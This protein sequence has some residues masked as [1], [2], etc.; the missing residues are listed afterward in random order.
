MG[1]QLNSNWHTHLFQ[2]RNTGFRKWMALVELL[3]L[4]EAEELQFKGTENI[5]NKIIK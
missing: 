4:E 1:G 5:F 2:E 3:G